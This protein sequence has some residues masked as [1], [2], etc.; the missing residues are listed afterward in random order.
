M[1]KWG[2]KVRRFGLMLVL[3]GGGLTYWGVT[4]QGWL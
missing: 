4:S 2:R 3:V 1:K